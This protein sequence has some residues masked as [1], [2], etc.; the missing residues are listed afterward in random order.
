LEYLIRNKKSDSDKKIKKKMSDYKDYNINNKYNKK[1][2][3]KSSLV[4]GEFFLLREI[5]GKCSYSQEYLSL[6]A[7]RGELK[8]EKFGRNWYTTMDWLR[9]YIDCHPAEKKGNFKGLIAADSKYKKFVAESEWNKS[10]DAAVKNTLASFTERFNFQVM[11]VNKFFEQ[12]FSRLKSIFVLHKKI[13][14][15]RASDGSPEVAARRQI[16]ISNYIEEYLNRIR[17]M[18][19]GLQIENCFPLFSRIN[20][21]KKLLRHYP[22]NTGLNKY[23]MLNA[24]EIVESRIDRVGINFFEL[25]T[26]LAKDKMAQIFFEITICV[27]SF[28]RS[29]MFVA[30]YFEIIPLA[31]KFRVGFATLLIFFLAGTIIISQVDHK[32]TSGVYDNTSFVVK[33]AVYNSERIFINT[34][35]AVINKIVKLDS[36]NL[37]SVVR[38]TRSKVA[39]AATNDLS[40]MILD[41]SFSWLNSIAKVK[42]RVL[43]SNDKNI[44]TEEIGRARADF[45]ILL[46]KIDY[47]ASRQDNFIYKTYGNF[48]E[49]VALNLLLE[50]TGFP[51]IN[52]NSREAVIAAGENADALNLGFK[53]YLDSF[54]DPGLMI[55][56]DKTAKYT[57]LE[58]LIVSAFGTTSELVG[59]AGEYINNL[60]DKTKNNLG[61]GYLALLDTLNLQ[62]SYTSNDGYRRLPVGKADDPLKLQQGAIDIDDSGLAVVPLKKD[63]GERT[64][65]VEQIKN[66]FSDEVE[67]VPDEDT[68]SGIIKPID[69]EISF[70]EYIYVVVPINSEVKN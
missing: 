13:G 53:N 16:L 19:L 29:P 20:Q 54:V 59:V 37:N 18:N 56:F 40:N 36:Q 45:R 62:I 25:L 9:E 58:K 34:G 2:F 23:I 60:F 31:R 33:N 67:V 68:A 43:H 6:L 24:L 52:S 28:F 46:E 50:M 57:R 35:E 4:D 48:A 15:T 44:Q 66:S 69:S 1:N 64:K 63:E 47:A 12:A 14:D 8:A 26:R 51:R 49:Y 22:F 27:R 10:V 65:L 55:L 41:K 3:D 61:N 70:A 38:E 5:S 39:G 42:E 7:R 32:F 11:H 17:N 30:R 21:T